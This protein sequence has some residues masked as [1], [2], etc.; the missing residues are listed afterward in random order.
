MR[1]VPQLLKK[2]Q[3]LADQGK[4]ITILDIDLMLDYTRVLY[5]DLLE[6]KKVAPVKTELNKAEPAPPP[7]T[8]D[9]SVTS[10]E[11]EILPTAKY[12]DIPDRDLR[13]LIG[14]ND[15]YLFINELFKDDKSAYDSAIKHLNT[16][17]TYSDAENWTRTELH[18]KHNWDGENATVASFYQLLKNCFS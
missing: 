11:P 6:I 12:N 15:K 10:T 1:R 13:T 16:F 18:K 2:L 17:T 4:D 7:Q 5:A 8:V 14:I 3:E 9:Q